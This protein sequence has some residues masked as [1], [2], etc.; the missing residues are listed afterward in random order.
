MESITYN[1]F[2]WSIAETNTHMKVGDCA[3]MENLDGRT[4]PEFLKL[5][6][7]VYTKC[8][9]GTWLP[10]LVVDGYVFSTDGTIRSLSNWAIQYTTPSSSPF[11]AWVIFWDYFIWFYQEWTNI[12]LL[13]IPIDPILWTWNFWGAVASFW[14]LVDPITAISAPFSVFAWLSQRN[15]SI[16]N[17]SE[18]ILYFSIDKKVYTTSYKF[19][20]SMII[21]QSLVFESR[22]SGMTRDQN[23]IN[24]YLW[25]GRKYLRWWIGYKTVEWYSDLWV[26]RLQKVWQAKNIDYFIASGFTWINNILY[27]SQGQS[28]KQIRQ[29]GKVLDWFATN[30]KFA[31]GTQCNNDSWMTSW[32]N[33]VYFPSEEKVG[34][35]SYGIRNE[36]NAYWFINE[37]M[38]SSYED[39][40]CLSYGTDANSFQELYIWVRDSNNN[41]FVL[42][43]QYDINNS[44]YKYQLEWVRYTKKEI[45]QFPQIKRS[46]KYF[47][48]YELPLGTT[49]EIYC[50]KDGTNNYT[51]LTTL[52]SWQQEFIFNWWVNEWREITHKIVMKTTD[53]TKTPKLQ[54]MTISIEPTKRWVSLQ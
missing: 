17:N 20:P 15:I 24:I 1:N 9:T 41:W 25:N 40:W 34:A 45:N 42:V 35:I 54:S 4:E 31:F 18:D 53:N 8:S 33:L 52:P 46:I 50:C 2:S 28:C 37:Y 27:I 19:M 51:L 44:L 39:I 38:S 3:Y 5:N 36:V 10:I 16:I 29:A 7:E 30:S 43:Q 13:S 14:V 21:E 23:S 26:S 22:V 12:K 6:R 47:F 11:V 49:I 48:R 32:N